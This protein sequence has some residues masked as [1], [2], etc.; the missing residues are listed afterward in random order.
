[1]RI[2]DSHVHFW[3]IGGPGQS[4]PDAAWPLIHRDFGIHELTAAVSGAGDAGGAI[5]LQG[6]VLVQSQPDDRDTDW[7]LEIARDTPLIQAVVGWVNLESPSA[8]TR[9]A[10][11]ADRP[12]L[13]GLRPMLQ[14]IDDTGWILKHELEPALEAMVQHR[15]RFDA[16]IQ[17]R[18]LPILLE[19][20]R[21]WP[22]LPIVIDHGAK[23]H[24]PRGE[25]EPWQ[26]QLAEL[27][28]LPNIYCKLS[29]LRTEQ[30]A[31]APSAELEPYIR[32]LVAS[33]PGRLMWGSDWPVLL[34][35]RDSYADWLQCALRYA[36]A[37]KDEQLDSLFSGAAREFYG[38]A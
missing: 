33:F 1:M 36:G 14:S 24:I 27:S 10:E 6:V 22:K 35:A 8:P 13:R 29:G 25:I 34:H 37:R 19:F 12:E 26:A 2:I 31:N 28:L 21:R 15:L 5:D 17:P 7:I 38:L 23:P 4:W 3:R 20:A 9:I 30:A 11:L 32:A 18:H 16:L